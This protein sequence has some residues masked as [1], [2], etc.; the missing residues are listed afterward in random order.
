MM[1]SWGGRDRREAERCKVD[2]PCK[3]VVSGN[4]WTGTT[5]D[6]SLTGAFF[7]PGKDNPVPD[8]YLSQPALF[9]LLLPRQPL[10]AD[11]TIVRIRGGAIGLRFL[12]F[13]GGSG[14]DVLVDFLE[15]QLSRVV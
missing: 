4:I 2:V 14:R 6:I 9:E 12:G 15:T 7:D 1:L 10:R 11:C 8:S 13:Q 5:K 3:L